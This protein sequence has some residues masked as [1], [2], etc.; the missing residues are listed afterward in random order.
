M[1]VLALLD[2][3]LKEKPIWSDTHHHRAFVISEWIS[4]IIQPP[5]SAPVLMAM[6]GDNDFESYL[7]LAKQVMKLDFGSLGQDIFDAV[8]RG[9]SCWGS[10]QCPFCCEKVY[11]AENPQDLIIRCCCGDR[12]HVSCFQKQLASADAIPPCTSTT[13]VPKVEIDHFANQFVYIGQNFECVACFLGGSSEELSQFIVENKEKVDKT[14]REESKK[15]WKKWPYLK[16]KKLPY[17][18]CQ[19]AGS[20]RPRLEDTAQRLITL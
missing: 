15:L 8:C 1:E 13:C 5:Q 4:F 14:D 12:T 2:P 9:Y 11:D 16:N 3:S 7:T 10:E 20:K 17:P 18:E 6:E 19:T